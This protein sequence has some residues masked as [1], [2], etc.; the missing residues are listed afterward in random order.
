LGYTIDKDI[1]EVVIQHHGT[2]F[3]SLCANNVLSLKKTN[4][5]EDVIKEI[6]DYARTINRLPI[7]VHDPDMVNDIL[8]KFKQHFSEEEIIN[9]DVDQNITDQHKLVCTTKIPRKS[10]V[11]KIPLFVSGATMLFGGDRQLWVQQSEK[12]VY[13]NNEV[14]NPKYKGTKICRLD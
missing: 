6:V 7:Y 11:D 8:D 13:L 4:L 9:L 14:Y 1:E 2:R 3:Y 5:K 10:L 12:V